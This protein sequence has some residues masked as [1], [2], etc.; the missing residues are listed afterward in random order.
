M[1][2]AF[3]LKAE[4]LLLR[5]SS[6]SAVLSDV[7]AADPVKALRVLCQDRFFVILTQVV[8]AQQVLDFDAA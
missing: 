7:L 4:T 8:A 5:Q 1:T 2:L 6:S 3:S